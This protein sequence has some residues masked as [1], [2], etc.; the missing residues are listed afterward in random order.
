MKNQFHASLLPVF[1]LML[2]ALASAGSDKPNILLIV[3]DDLGYS[4]I[5]CFGSEIPTPNL[6]RLGS[7]GLRFTRFYNTA[8]C[9]PSRASILTGL[10]PH[11]AGVGF[12]TSSSSSELRRILGPPGYLDNLN[13]KCVTIAEVLR[14]TGYKTYLSGKWHVGQERPHWPVDR[15]FDRSFT[16]LGGYHYFDPSEGQYTL[17]DRS[18]A[19]DPEGFYSTDY[20]TDRAVEFLSQHQTGQPFFLYLAYTAPHWPLHAP[21]DEVARFEGSYMRGWDEMRKERY[22]KMLS[23]GVLESNVLL[24]P[25]DGHIPAW[26]DL[27]EA[28]K[29]VWDRKMAVYAAQVSRMDK[30]IGRVV[31][32]LEENGMLDNTLLLFVSDNGGS[33]EN[34]RKGDRN[35]RIGTAQSWN[36][37]GAW[38]NLSNAPFRLFKHYV[39]EGGMRSPFIAHW[40]EVIRQRKGEFVRDPCHIID[41]MATCLEAAGADY[42]DLFNGKPVIPSPGRSLVPFFRGE[43]PEHH[44]ILYWEH[45]GNRALLDGDW[46]LVSQLGQE[47]ELY[48]VDQ[49]PSEL[50]DLAKEYP[51]RIK[52]LSKNWQAWADEVGVVPWSKTGKYPAV[53]DYTK[54]QP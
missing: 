51:E 52:E 25:R 53:P 32:L 54:L 10:Y 37:Y 9:S 20:I 33:A 43:S 47:W 34:S 21:E 42:P 4:D 41:L 39:H 29:L 18:Y 28:D 24:S 14:T 38:A 50:N 35:A 26:D 44:Q 19:P 2:A 3:A 48:R 23:T 31:S 15:G 40:P 27:D 12:L 5:G 49:D 36:S 45:E 16:F 13:D 17:D 6:D 22:Q 11:Q 30:G 8:R 46:K 7:N 1:V